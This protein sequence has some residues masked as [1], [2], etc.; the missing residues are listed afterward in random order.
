AS[1]AAGLAALP[2]RPQLNEFQVVSDQMGF[3]EFVASRQAL[4]L[5]VIAG[6]QTRK[7]HPRSDTRSMTVVPQSRA[8]LESPVVPSVPS[9]TSSSATKTESSL[10]TGSVKLDV[11]EEDEDGILNV[12]NHQHAIPLPCTLS[13]L[14]CFFTTLDS[15]VWSTHCTSHFRG[16]Q[17]PRSVQ[18]PFLTCDW[19][20]SAGVGIDAWKARTDHI[21]QHYMR[22]DHLAHPVGA[23]RKDTHLFEYLWGTRVISDAQLKELKRFGKLQDTWEDYTITQGSTRDQR[24]GIG[25]PG[26]D[27][28]QERRHHEH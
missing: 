15:E 24:R 2:F 26:P 14:N 11:L 6:A 13:F 18:C 3:S 23:I 21:H 1:L 7:E 9:L 8:S 25:L 17:P 10:L 4:P 16:N 19:K 22:N 20:C 28:R 27:R 5:V 12:P